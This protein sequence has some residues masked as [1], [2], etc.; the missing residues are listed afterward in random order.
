MQ[1]KL[2]KEIPLRGMVD[3]AAL[4]LYAQTLK[5]AMARWLKAGIPNIT[6]W[7]G[8]MDLI[9]AEVS[10]DDVEMAQSLRLMPE[11]ARERLR[12]L[13]QNVPQFISHQ[14]AVVPELAVWKDDR[15]VFIKP[16]E[17]RYWMR[18]SA[19]NDA[20]SIAQSI[21]ATAAESRRH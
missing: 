4:S 16:N 8:D 21:A 15:L 5:G 2:D 20:D 10:V 18:S 14:I 3:A 6:I 13:R 12:D 11:G 19:L 17:V 1:P 7:Q 9:V